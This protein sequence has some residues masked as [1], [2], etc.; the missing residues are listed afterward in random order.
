MIAVPMTIAGVGAGLLFRRSVPSALLAGG[1][2]VAVAALKI[3]TLPVACLGLV[4]RSSKGTHTVMVSA[5]N[6]QARWPFVTA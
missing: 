5:P 1:L 4:R 2:L 3:V 6:P